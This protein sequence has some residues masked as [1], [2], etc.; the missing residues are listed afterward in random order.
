EVVRTEHS[1]PV[2]PEAVMGPILHSL[3][4][5]GLIGVV[6]YAVWITVAGFRELKRGGGTT[7]P[8]ARPERAH[9]AARRPCPGCG[10]KIPL[11]ERSCEACGLRLDS[12]AGKELRELE[13]TARRV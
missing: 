5:L 6:V 12:D 8:A 7:A 1:H 10:E 2:H 4:L 9:P 13:I 11:G 3:V